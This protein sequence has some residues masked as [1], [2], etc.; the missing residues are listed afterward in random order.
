[1]TG[2][3]IADIIR[4]GRPVLESKG[5]LTSRQKGML[6][7]IE[8]CRTEALGGM[9]EYCSSCDFEQ[10]FHPACRNRHCPKCQGLNQEEWI[11]KQRERTLDM[12]HFHL[13]FT[14]PSELRRLSRFAP[15]LVYSLLMKAVGQTLTDFADRHW[16]ATLG[17][18]LILHTWNRKLE[19]HPHVH[20]IVTGGGLVYDRE[21]AFLCPENF[22]FPIAALAKVFR[23]KVMEAAEEV[24]DRGRF[25]GFADFE[26]PEAFAKLKKVLFKKKWYVYAKPA[27]DLAE[28]VLQYL[29]RY[30]HRV[31]ISKSRLLSMT[32]ETVTFRTRGNQTETT[33][34]SEFVRR[35][36]MHVLPKGFH[37]IR[38]I[39]LNACPEKRDKLA[40]L[41]GSKR[42]LR[43]S[44]D[45]R[46]RLIELTGRDVS[47][48]PKCGALLSGHPL[49]PVGSP[50]APPLN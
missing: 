24:Y 2:F 25:A 38:H 32:K 17:A 28:H 31:G 14:L 26:D 33:A 15:K 40:Q 11:E 48:C 16:K 3:D 43:L 1:M 50:R 18:T 45:W 42:V 20:A 30:T 39:G 8:L 12:R 23:G 47:A 9:L 7:S 46:Q 22:I 13:V 5:R 4:Q 36:V 44:K 10:C 19:L 21:K 29:G 27:F 6:T 37:K 35:F 41:L 49:P 34:P